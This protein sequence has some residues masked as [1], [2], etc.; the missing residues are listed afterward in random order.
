[1]TRR[2][3]TLKAFVAVGIALVLC[4]VTLPPH[5]RAQ[6]LTTGTY[7]IGSPSVIDIFVNGI[8]GDDDNNG[9]SVAA[10]LRTV[11][12]AWRRIPQ[13]QALT[14]SGFRIN[15]AG[16]FYSES[17]LP[18]YWESRHGTATAPIIMQPLEGTGPVVLGGDINMF[19]TSYFYLLD[20]TIAPVPAGDA[21][22]CE[23]CD[24]ILL[25]RTVLNGGARAAHE[26]LKINQSHHIY[27]EDSDIHGADDNAIDF[28]AVHYGHVVRNKIHDAQDWCAYVKGGSAFL[29]IEANQI[30]NCGTGGFTAGQGTGF[31]FMSPP[32]IHYEAYDIKF[33]NNAIFDTEGAAF[34]VNG[35]YN[36]LLAYNTAYRVGSRDHLIE[37]V[38]GARS[39]DGDAAA[40]NARRLAGGWG[41]GQPEGDS[42]DKSVPNRNVFVLN[43]IVYN[44]AGYAAPQQVFA[45]YGPR[46]TRPGSNLPNPAFADDN[47]QIK[48]NL[49]WS[50]NSAGT[51][52]GV[53][54][55]RQGC[56][57]ENP[58]CNAAQ[59]VR[60]NS[61][62]E[63]EP[64]L[65]NPGSA[66][67]DRDFRPIAASN[68][69][70]VSAIVLTAFSGGDRPTVP[71][72]PIGNVDNTVLRDRGGEPRDPSVPVV[73]AY[74]SATSP[75][76][77]APGTP[78]GIGG[79]DGGAGSDGG[80]GGIGNADVTPPSILKAK[81][82]KRA[83]LRKRISIDVTA[84]D[85][86]GVSRVFATIGSNTY[87]LT[88]TG[89]ASKHRY[90]A[91]VRAS[92]RGTF[93]VIISAVDAANN[94]SQA[95]GG[96]ITV[97]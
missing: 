19:D 78:G 10:P 76:D 39:C 42:D 52:L 53:G 61:I 63:I 66:G 83:K 80:D 14:T 73:G 46:S 43:N 31:E 54:G 84:I 85:D 41:P 7:D 59:I 24:H 12:A 74:A 33:F 87:E 94:M 48:G 30:Y 68:V 20:I 32:F 40:C 8:S 18:T 65:Q 95:D 57:A 72:V 26:T 34:G 17:S 70:S 88:P 22:H 97:K 50:V 21:F 86:T 9:L 47:L 93:D 35:G 82:T 56:L 91:K 64:Q 45:V 16:G 67:A 81:S 6:S 90:A 79:G 75:R 2:Y 60:D 55:E 77:P 23:Q 37:I 29:T 11:D 13:S 27:I 36:I 44:P 38:F 49:I 4:A 5:A 69:F 71:A 3:L 58:T 96:R 51:D 92:Q 1:M 89:R 15:L 62:N 28:V 25:R